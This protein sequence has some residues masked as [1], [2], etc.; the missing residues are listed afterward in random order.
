MDIINPYI[1]NLKKHVALL[2]SR[3]KNLSAKNKNLATENS[4]LLKKIEHLEHQIEVFKKRVE[5]ID[6]VDGISGK[7]DNS[8]SF[9]R[10]RLNNLIRQIDQCIS[11]LNE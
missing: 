10:S 7:D 8:S 9:A 5:V 4:G 6:L 2:V 3:Y 1:L 11:L